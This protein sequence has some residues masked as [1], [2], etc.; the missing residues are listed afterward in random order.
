MT[1]SQAWGPSK[2]RTPYDCMKP[3]CLPASQF[4]PRLC[5]DTL[6]N[7]RFGEIALSW[8]PGTLRS[9]TAPLW[10]WPRFLF[11]L[12]IC[13]WVERNHLSMCYLRGNFI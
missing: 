2:C 12:S 9:H 6:Q 10:F 5:P 4:L 8:E 7:M 13:L 11:T 3:A 1:P